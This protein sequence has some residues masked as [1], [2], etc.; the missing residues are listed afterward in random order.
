MRL[1]ELH[2]TIEND[3]IREMTK[4]ERYGAA[5]IVA[6]AIAKEN[7][8]ETTTDEFAM[9]LDNILNY[10]FSYSNKR[11]ELDDPL[12]I[13]SYI[14]TSLW[15]IKGSGQLYVTIEEEEGYEMIGRF[16]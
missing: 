6:E 5:Y 10:N 8:I 4:V 1:Q 13:S 15:Q 2:F 9:L 3:K 7:G 12:L 16:E 11:I 14:I